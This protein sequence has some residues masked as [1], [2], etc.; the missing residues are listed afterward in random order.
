MG[1]LRTKWGEQL[2]GED[3][4]PEYPRPAMRRDYF[5]NL[6]GY[7]DYAITKKCQTPCKFFGK[8]LVPF[9]PE[10]ELSGVG[11]QLKPDEYLW[12]RRILPKIRKEDKG[13]RIL[14]HFGAVDQAC[15][16]WLN[17]KYVA[18][19][20]GGYLP[21]TVDITRFYSEKKTV[22][23]MVVRDLSDTSYHT[24]GKQKLN[25]KG[26]FYTA[27]SGIWQTV[28]MEC[29]PQNYIEKIQCVPCF[30]EKRVDITVFSKQ[31]ESV[32]IE[33]G[34]EE[35][36]DVLGWTNETISLKF[37]R[38]HPWSPEDPWLYPVII[39][40]KN[41]QVDTY[42][43]MRIFSIENNKQGIPVLCLNHKPYYQKGVLDQGY[44]PDGLYTAP[45]DAA[46][47]YDI[48]KMKQMGFRMIRK[49]LKI[50]PQRWYYHCDRLGM[51][52]WQDMVNGGASYHHWF[53]T[54]LAT[55]F[56]QLGI[57]TKDNHPYL[58]S[59]KDR[60]GKQEFVRE[61]K[62]TIQAL[63]IHPSIA[64]WVLFNE[65][66]GQFETKQLTGIARKEDPTRLIDSSSGWFDQGCGDFQSR[67]HYFFRLWFSKKDKRARVLSEY[68]GYSLKI[69]GHVE[70][71]KYMD[72]VFL[73]PFR[74]IVWHWKRRKNKWKHFGK[75]ED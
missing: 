33:V 64:V 38:I 72:I 75:N 2:N 17:G 24:R 61:M 60:K 44:W 37:E 35:K 57:P 59:R 18:R 5:Y 73:K 9:S 56:L 14:L 26:M 47:I 20:E 21:F 16:I 34:G 31:R 48:V 1:K 62:G 69:T 6:N 25:A 29:V 52:V 12:Y 50:E 66:W 27:Q 13:K 23:T 19:H 74:R 39:K 43:A 15:K 67:H 3:I 40:T 28:W 8:I 22:L 49:H 71:K 11:R 10:S 53:V 68:G 46:M 55:L 65:G 45:S 51:I 30:D 7:W 42:F 4:L 54:Y 41:D 63:S 58:L 32:V 36:K 70:K